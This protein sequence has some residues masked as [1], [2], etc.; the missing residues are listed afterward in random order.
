MVVL[1]DPTSIFRDALV[2]ETEISEECFKPSIEGG[3]TGALVPKEHGSSVFCS[4]HVCAWIHFH[5][6]FFGFF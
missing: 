2:S 1:L 5:K 4:P 6:L 3:R